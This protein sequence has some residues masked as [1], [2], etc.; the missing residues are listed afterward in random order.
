MENWLAK[1]AVPQS[2]GVDPSAKA[3]PM[4][5]GALPLS[6]KIVAS[7]VAGRGLDRYAR[8]SLADGAYGP[9]LPVH[10]DTR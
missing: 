4:V 1:D 9:L 6:S 7:T 2:G 3:R 8:G 5:S 10:R